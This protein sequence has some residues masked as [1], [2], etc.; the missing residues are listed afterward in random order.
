MKFLVLA[1]MFA[2]SIMIIHGIYDDKYRRMKKRL[3]VQYRFIPRT[4]YDEQLENASVVGAN[5]DGPVADSST[6]TSG[7]VGRPQR[8]ADVF[9]QDTHTYNSRN[10]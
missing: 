2:G 5:T 10:H 9:D 3:K 4:Y 8:Y 6:M 7:G 1:L